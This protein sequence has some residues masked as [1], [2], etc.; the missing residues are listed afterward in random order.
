MR[1]SKLLTLQAYSSQ[2][3]KL[4]SFCLVPPH[5]YRIRLPTTRSPRAVILNTDVVHTLALRLPEG[6]QPQMSH[7][8]SP[9]LEHRGFQR[10]FGT[11]LRPVS[12][13]NSRQ[14]VAAIG[15]SRQPL[16]GTGAQAAASKNNLYASATCRASQRRVISTSR[17]LESTTGILYSCTGYG[18]MGD[19]I[20][21][22]RGKRQVS[23]LVPTTA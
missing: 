20:C 1:Y 6:H 12:T 11:S 5:S 3:R 10:A 7:R 4:N 2:H 15:H 17:P 16:T 18:C 22:T 14:E 19:C 8:H 9:L 21:H 13:W 23:A